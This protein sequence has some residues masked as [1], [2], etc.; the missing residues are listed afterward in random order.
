MD[1]KDETRDNDE[2]NNAAD[3]DLT[4]SHQTTTNEETSKADEISKQISDESTL[5]TAVSIDIT[6][7]IEINDADTKTLT[8]E[9]DNL[10]IEIIKDEKDEVKVGAYDFLC[11]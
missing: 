2:V 11:I 4:S 10:D 3:K 6:S 9:T 1:E 5:E 8:A 7:E